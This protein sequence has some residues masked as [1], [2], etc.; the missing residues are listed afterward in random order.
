NWL[1]H[2]REV[3]D[4]PIWDAQK[5]R[6]RSPKKRPMTPAEVRKVLQAAES[7]RL[8]ALWTLMLVHGLRISEALG[9]SWEYVDWHDN[10]ISIEYQLSRPGG[11]GCS[12]G[13]PQNRRVEAESSDEQD[14][15]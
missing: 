3:P 11:S 6:Y 9:L 5:P 2:G 10:L 12:L 1:M 7:D 8:G 13:R 15:A 4:N 14:G